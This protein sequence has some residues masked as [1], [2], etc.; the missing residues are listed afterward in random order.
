MENRRPKVS[1]IIP[2][3]NVISY[4]AECLESAINQT[5]KDIE[6]ICVDA[7]STDGTLEVINSYA[8]NDNRIKLIVS[9]KKSYGYQM[10]MAMDVAAGEYIGI[11]ESDDYV[12]LDMYEAL[13]KIAKE[14]GLDFIKSD[15]Y[16][17]TSKEDGSINSAYHN[18]AWQSKYYNKV[19]K[20]LEE[21]IAFRFIMNTWSGIYRNE[22]I[23]GNSIRHNETPGASFQDNGFWF[24]TFTLAERA[25]FLDKAYYMNR[26]D[27][28]NSSVFSKEKVYC[29]CEEYDYIRSFLQ[30]N[31]CLDKL[32]FL[33]SYICYQNYKFNLNRIA[34]EYKLEFLE[35]CS[36]DFRKMRDNGEL[37]YS[38][39]GKAEWEILLSIIDNPKEYYEK[40]IV[41]KRE[42]IEKI[43]GYKN[44]I[45]YGVGMV[46]K[47]ILS[48]LTYVAKPVN[49][50]CFAVSDKKGNPEEFKGVPIYGIND[51]THHAE[52]AAI[53]VAT[54]EQYHNEIISTL[55]KLNFKNIILVSEFGQNEEYHYAALS[56]EDYPKE[57]S[58]WYYKS[59][60]LILNLENPKSFNEKIQWLKLNDDNALKRELLDKYESRKWVADRIGDKY[61]VPLL[62]VWDKFND[63]DF[64]KL[65]DSFVLKTTHGREFNIFVADKNDI[66]EFDKYSVKRRIE[67][68]LSKDY[69]FYFGFQTEYRGIKPRIIAEPM[70]GNKVKEDNY[71]FLCFNGEPKYII[72][73]TK[74]DAYADCRRDIFDLDWRHQPYEIKYPKADSIP[75]QPV[76]LE[77][78]T[79]IAKKL[80][81]GFKFIRIDLFDTKEKVL[82]NEVKFSIGSGVEYFK[83]MSF[84]N[85]L[86]S[87]INI[88]ASEM[89]G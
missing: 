5:L 32:K 67:E 35:K 42:L 82:F 47:R 69:V 60:G 71:K 62:G 37:D 12:K 1:I 17:F 52:D 81:E 89:K 80:C 31:N 13:Y 66:E 2:S 15:F 41:Q 57:L 30:K 79:E 83:Q 8:A 24:Q 75:D 88:K 25:Y 20:P 72:V 7:G 85:Q 50:I 43:T 84:A 38:L 78:M 27:N 53:V 59:T 11:I 6:I 16:R 44:V 3:L 70:I 56:M 77:E 14:N 63:I 51:L 65:P 34:E 39:F 21:R 18:I 28:P 33:F 45:I 10:N 86:G 23:K 61:L 26:R 68:W 58:Q 73:D 40:A 54:T 9:E 64:E 36:A 29:I 48:E 22:F 87:L 46:G 4:I 49:V 19:I 76:H 74:K 55:E